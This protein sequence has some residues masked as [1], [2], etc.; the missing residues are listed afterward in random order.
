MK[1]R[2]LIPIVIVFILFLAW[3]VYH[4]VSPSKKDQGFGQGR[5]AVAVE[6]DNINQGPIEDVRLFTGTVFPLYRYQVAS[7]VA[8]RV[9]HFNKRIGDYVR[10]D[11]TIAT[12]DDA[13]FRQS[14]LEAEANLAIAKA[15][16]VDA[17][18]QLELSQREFDR[19]QSLHEQGLNSPSDFDAARSRLEAQNAKLK[20]AEAQVLQREAALE[21]EKIQLDYTVL[22]ASEPGYIGERLVDEGALLSVNTP[23][24]SVIGIDT[25]YIR[26]S[27][28]E[29]D[30]GR[31]QIGQ[32]AF[33]TVD[34]FPEQTFSGRVSRIAP[35]LRE[36]SRVAEM[37]VVV[38]NQEQ[39]L[40]PGMYARVRVVLDSRDNALLVPTKAVVHSGSQNGVF[41]V[42][43]GEPATAKWVPVA[44]G[45]VG[46]AY[47][48]ILDPV[49]IEGQVVSLGQHLL[50]DGGKILLPDPV[51]SPSQ[52][53][54][55][56]GE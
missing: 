1:K 23:L 37:E 28:I 8:G 27:I 51:N 9:V 29:R 15:S 7:K 4:L 22:R 56:P 43:P 14:M 54:T 47:T 40:K 12:L 52:P 42:V 20:V 10:R 39:L 55:S 3:R 18:A 26:T 33:I 6:T 30:Y 31:M 48:E 36:E 41:L 50:E 44:T 13:E 17:K 38:K 2:I 5:P 45:I 24:A 34:A 32:E 53:G 11:E 25:V 46:E 21:V 19:A 35:M 16:L 49:N